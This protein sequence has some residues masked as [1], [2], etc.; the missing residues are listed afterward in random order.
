MLFGLS[1]FRVSAALESARCDA[2][3]AVG[4]TICFLNGLVKGLLPSFNPRGVV[5]DDDCSVFPRSIATVP[6]GTPLLQ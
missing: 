3:N 6:A 2:I 1:C 5:L 4:P